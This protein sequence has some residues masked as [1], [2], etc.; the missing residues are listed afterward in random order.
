MVDVP[1]ALEGLTVAATKNKALTEEDV[2]IAQA[3][4]ELLTVGDDYGPK[5]Y[6]HDSEPPTGY[7]M[8]GYDYT[9]M[10]K[11]AHTGKRGRPRMYVYDEGLLDSG[12]DHQG[13]ST[14]VLQNII[15]AQSVYWLLAD[16]EDKH[17]V[18]WQL[19]HFYELLVSDRYKHQGILEQIGRMLNEGLINEF[20]AVQL[21]KRAAYLCEYSGYRSKDVERMLRYVHKEIK[22]AVKK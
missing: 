8:D 21:A 6:R 17:V 15:N 16:L 14:R 3:I 13:M 12:H 5:W 20:H 19:T 18:S 7:S 10:Q 9:W 4:N 1:E 2:K 22:D 11:A